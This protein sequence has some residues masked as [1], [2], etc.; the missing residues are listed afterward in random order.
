MSHNTPTIGTAT[1]GRAGDLATSIGDLDDVALSSIAPS[2]ILKYNSSA[3]EW[4]NHATS[5]SNPIYAYLWKKK[6]ST[7]WSAGATYTVHSLDFQWR[8]SVSPPLLGTGVTDVHSPY[9]TWA[10]AITVPA[11]NYLLMTQPMSNASAGQNITWRWY[12]GSAYFG[13]HVFHEP[14]SAKGGAVAAAVYSAAA[15]TTLRLKVYAKSATI[16]F[17]QIENSKLIGIH[18]TQI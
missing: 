6:P 14:T 4:R 8:T 17:A 1:Q 16:G 12:D 10:G 3:S 2:D 11:G 5:V 9:T 15:S 7:S 13:P 18:I